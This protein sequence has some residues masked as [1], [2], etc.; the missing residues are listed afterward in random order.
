MCFLSVLNGN[1]SPFAQILLHVKQRFHTRWHLL[2]LARLLDA[3][4]SLP[5]ERRPEQVSGVPPCVAA[6]PSLWTGV[7]ATVVAQGQ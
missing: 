1:L 4:A 7:H 3:P 5:D 6:M 2:L